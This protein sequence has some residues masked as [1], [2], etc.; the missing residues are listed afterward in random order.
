M[1]AD[2]ADLRESLQASAEY[3]KSIELYTSLR[4]KLKPHSSSATEEAAPDSK[5]EI[6]SGLLGDLAAIP[7][8]PAEF[9]LY[10]KGAIH[11]HSGDLETSIRCWKELLELPAPERQFRSTWAAYMLGKCYL[12]TGQ[13]TLA[14]ENFELVKRLAASG[15]KDSLG[16]VQGSYGWNAHLA[17]NAGSYGEAIALYLKQGGEPSVITSLRM[18]ARKALEEASPAEL[19]DLGRNYTNRNV[20]TSFIISEHPAGTETGANTSH[21]SRVERWLSALEAASIKDDLM[22]ERMALAAYQIGNMDLSRRW[23]ELAPKSTA[24]RW[25]K[26]KL[27]IY[28]GKLNDAAIILQQLSL[29]FPRSPKTMPSGLAHS[30]HLASS[31]ESIPAEKQLLGD[32]GVVQLSRNQFVFSLDAFLKAGFWADAAYVAERVL[33]LSELQIYVDKNC[34]S[35]ESAPDLQTISEFD[36][37]SVALRNLLA[38]RLMRANRLDEARPYFNAECLPIYER[39]IKDM[40]VGFGPLEDSNLR[41]QHRFDAAKT[42]RNEGRKLLATECEPDWNIHP[43]YAEGLTEEDR[44][45]AIQEQIPPSA[46]ERHRLVESAVKPPFRYHFR[47]VAAELAWHAALIMPN[48]DEE[49][50]S[51]LCQAGSWIKYLNPK[52]ADRFYKALVRRCRQT[53]IGQAADQ[54][55]WFPILNA[56]GKLKQPIPVTDTASLQSKTE[57]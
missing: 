36:L 10:I 9:K 27:L 6:S 19:L 25:L 41:A 7:T 31:Y 52:R 15:Y 35:S 5:V 1:E 38:R 4:R 23:I 18:T 13:S 39:F 46:E 45:Q 2:L 8:L 20:I 11:W 32:L 40:R 21:S 54:L 26:A 28:D 56:E 55:R 53:S 30:L 3:E 29:T 34:P 14:K 37:N 47:Y 22:A 48:N 44:L 50:A 12:E 24:A 49:T 16:L 17:F 51:V 33:S 43:S 57:I 42:I